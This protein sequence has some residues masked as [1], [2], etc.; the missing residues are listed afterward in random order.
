MAGRGVHGFDA[1]LKALAGAI[2]VACGFYYYLKVVRA[3]YWQPPSTTDRIPIS[4]LSRAAMI[5]LIIG[6]FWLGVYPRPILNAL[7]SKEEPVMTVGA[8]DVKP[9]TR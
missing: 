9:L 7:N 3:M 6:T 8:V 1:F 2:G 4:A 5:V